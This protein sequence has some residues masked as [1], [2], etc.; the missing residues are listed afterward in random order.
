[1][2]AVVEVVK[3]AA[4]WYSSHSRVLEGTRRSFL[5]YPCVPRGLGT[6]TKR[7]SCCPL[8]RRGRPGSPTSA[9][10]APHAGLAGYSP[11]QPS[12]PWGTLAA[13]RLVGEHGWATKA[14]NAPPS[15]G[16]TRPRTGPRACRSRSQ[17]SGVVGNGTLLVALAAGFGGAFA[18]LLVISIT[19]ILRNRRSARA[20][21]PSTP[22]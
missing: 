5:E 7:A 6:P 9:G 8:R 11:L 12:P 15:V 18:L 13:A 19:M 3:G 16:H 22:L 14:R 4:P 20:T 1:M 10:P 17:Q 21:E 2:Q